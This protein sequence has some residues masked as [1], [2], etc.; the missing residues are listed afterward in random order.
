M[1]DKSIST[2]SPTVK[3]S[4][5]AVQLG[6]ITEIDGLRAVAVIG[7][8]YAHVW[9][10]GCGNIAL[11]VGSFDINRA[12][13]VFGTGVDL[14][15]VISGF[16]IYLAYI[17]T[18]TALTANSY[19]KFLR[20]RLQRI[21]PAYLAAV[22]FAALVWTVNAKVFPVS[23]VIEHLVF[24]QILVADGNQL[25]APFWSLAT[26]WHF[27]LALPLL[28]ATARTFNYPT[29]LLIA[30]SMCIAWRAVTSFSAAAS[31]MQLQ[32]RLTEFLLGIAVARLYLTER[33]LPWWLQGD[34]GVLLGLLVMLAGRA[35]MTDQALTSWLRPYAYALNT[36]VLAT[37]YSMILWSVI[38]SKS[39]IAAILRSPPLQFIGRIS[40]SFY[41]W[42]W[43]V[44]I[45]VGAAI[46]AN[47]NQP[48][49]AP[50]LATL[51][52]IPLVSILALCSYKFLELPYFD[53][54]AA[55]VR[56]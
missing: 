6:R 1:R 33:P 48:A 4:E 55:R 52:A 46:A 10:F 29:T 9:A 13:S 21:Y 53:N 38:A 34:K 27:Y 40:Y 36:T 35:M 11:V 31:D 37:G 51:I 17:S 22:I 24:V 49:F 12:L 56:L 16:C 54:R 23:Q 18:S 43:F 44:A 8:L 15:F 30:A 26:E 20:R 50:I 45:W 7:V 5:R 39:R 19:L 32:A 14:F 47:L 41:L 28:I 25:A 3:P 42:H 2:V